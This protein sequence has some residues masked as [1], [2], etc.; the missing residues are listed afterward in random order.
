MKSD[1]HL[2][3]PPPLEA[4]VMRV[5]RAVRSAAERTIE[6]LGLAV[7]AASGSN[8]EALQSG[9]YELNRK[10][11]A[12]LQAFG[13]AFDDQVGR[14]CHPRRHADGRN[15]SG[16]SAWQDLGLV[17][18][19]DVEVKVLAERF[20]M[21]I[22]HICEWE[23]RE[24]EAYVGSVLGHARAERERNP[25][26]PEIVGQGVIRGLE[27]VIDRADVRKVVEQEL[28]RSLAAVLRVTYGDIVRDLRKAGIE[29]VSLT[30]RMHDSHGGHGPANG[31]GGSGADGESGPGGL[32]GHAAGTHGTAP[33]TSPFGGAHASA[34]GTSSDGGHA[35]WF[36]TDSRQG[37]LR[38]GG[39]TATFGQVEPVMM[40]LL[41]QLVHLEPASHGYDDSAPH[42]VPG[43]PVAPNLIRANRDQL[44]QASRGAID[45]MVIDV[46]GSLFDQILSDSKV[47][48]Q[49][50]RQ[51]ARLQLPVLRAALGDPTFFSSRR[52]P[53]RLFVN[54]I[55]SLGQGFDDY[56]D[57]QAQSFVAKVKDLVEEI[58]K[59]DFDQ[60]GTYEARL[61]SLEN[62]AGELAHQAVEA[63]QH[64]ATALLEQ[65]EVALRA[66]HHYE[67]QL[68]SELK[69]L[70]APAFVRDFVTRIWSRVILKAAERDGVTSEHVRVLRQVGRELFMSVQP[71]ASPAQ[72]K[73]FLADLPRLMQHLNGGLNSIG[74]PEAQRRAFFAQLMPAHAE[75][76]KTVT[77]RVLDF[78]MMARQVEQALERGMPTLD[79][80]APAPIDEPI[81][82]DAITPA[83][84]REEARQLGLVDEN[85][86]DWS[87]RVDIDVAEPELAAVDLELPGLPAPTE[88]P[89]PASGRSLADHVQIG[90]SYQMNLE[91]QWQKVRLSHVS[92]GRS[93]FVFTRGQRHQRTVSL[94][95]RMLVRMCEAGRL[96][97]YEQAE[98]LERATAR[99]R[100]QLASLSHVPTAAMG[101]TVPRPSA[102]H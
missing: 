88:A 79:E 98:L 16:Y 87:Q 44:R 83:F 54:R 59:G 9:Q 23:L 91:G 26:R 64:G 84:S 57:E 21:E 68:E 3:L 28:N 53:V 6:S 4:A 76:L 94:T 71:K 55:A 74:W 75:A 66:S 100:R 95:Q 69:P 86:V 48:P 40:D 39:R 49:L 92:P 81:G 62:F 27:T 96:R 80:L 77:N 50:A 31:T 51:I 52:H 22:T 85:A 32:Q 19:H 102:L 11:P 42:L 37:G 38:N 73:A 13:D 5:K 101:G 24:L 12:F 46:I 58:V 34:A 61:A 2:L 45:H 36:G 78:N 70:A 72:R 35:S 56:G 97:A 7:M 89:E 20:A 15:T 14:E 33:G 63:Q 90:F 29:P 82:D 93:F 10:L 43:T 60:I 30:V 65:R 8:R 1:A 18:D 99:T 25:L 67:R 41:R 17:D 47:P